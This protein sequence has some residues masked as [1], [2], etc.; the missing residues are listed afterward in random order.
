MLGLTAREWLC[1]GGYTLT[2]V[3]T[4]MLWAGL[5]FR[6]LFRD[7][8]AVYFSAVGVGAVAFLIIRAPESLLYALV[9]SWSLSLWVSGA[10][11]ALGN[12]LF[13]TLLKAIAVYVGR[14]MGRS[15]IDWLAIGVAVGLGYGWWE[16][17][18][19]VVIPLGSAGIWFPLAILGRFSSIGLHIGLSYLIA[20]ALA[21]QSGAASFLLL[22]LWRAATDYLSVFYQGRVIGIW[23][24]EFGT[25]FM[26]LLTVLYAYR[27]HRFKTP[28]EPAGTL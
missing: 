21:Q 25:L 20:R 7:R 28:A 2:F 4:G 26:A 5:F 24:L 8:I 9:G 15:E 19:Y 13:Q 1:M 18:R 3:L 23:F 11:V 27:L 12:A 14:L 10:L 17:W 22:I 16:A 6:D